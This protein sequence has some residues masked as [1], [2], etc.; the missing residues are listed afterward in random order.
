[1]SLLN[2]K[3]LYAIK[4]S[5]FSL[6]LTFS[7]S[8][9]SLAASSIESDVQQLKQVKTFSMGL[10]GF[11]GHISENEKTYRRVL[12]DKKARSIF[13][14]L[15]ADHAASMESKIYAACGLRS[16]SKADFIT[17]TKGLRSALNRASVLRGDILQMES[18]SDLLDHIE[19]FGCNK[20]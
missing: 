6:V 15:I 11:V 10:V 9:P 18:V 17:H 3:V 4:A 7:N 13:T 19:K 20:L 14:D 5:A 12:N 2:K 8:P 1:M 16:F